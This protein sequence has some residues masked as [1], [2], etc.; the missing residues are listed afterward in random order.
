[1][2]PMPPFTGVPAQRLPALLDAVTAIGSEDDLDRLLHRIVTTAR[3]LIGA[4]YAALGVLGQD[5]RLVGFVH[6]GIDASVVR[7]IGRPPRAVGILGAL[8]EDGA[9]VRLDDL[10]ADPRFGG[11][12]RHH[13]VMQAFLGVGLR[14]AGSAVGNLYLADKA[15]GG[16]FTDEDE[17]LVVSL[18]AVAAVAVRL[19]AAVRHGQQ[20]ERWVEALRECTSALLAGHD[21]ERL[22]DLVTRRGVG[23]VESDLAWVF[24]TD[25]ESGEFVVAAAAGGR[26]STAKGTR[27]PIATSLAGR[28]IETGRPV[29][30][31]DAR[32]EPVRFTLVPRSGAGPA[33]L[34][35]LAAGDEV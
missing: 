10:T 20:R 9:P 14:I 18:S 25:G 15:S 4:R 34:L 3:S 24:V 1:M 22:L 11:F 5:G 33:I 8:T 12:P 16:S 21:S 26:A 30:I 13:P 7:K 28:A 27:L 29:V 32:D 23:I 2:P 19:A 35:P 31:E 17:A 6:D